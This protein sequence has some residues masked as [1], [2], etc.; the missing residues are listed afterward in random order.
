M[1]VSTHPTAH[2][3]NKTSNPESKIQ[4]PEEKGKRNKIINT[5]TYCMWRCQS[6]QEV[7]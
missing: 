1:K 7:P 2:K 5:R 3:T 6:A 4:R